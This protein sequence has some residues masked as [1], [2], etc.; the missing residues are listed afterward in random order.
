M[1]T[2]QTS[3][4]ADTVLDTLSAYWTLH[5]AMSRDAWGERWQVQS[6]EPEPAK[7]EMVLVLMTGKQAGLEFLIKIEPR[8]AGG[9]RVSV[10]YGGLALSVR[11]T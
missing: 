2:Y 5:R 3:L 8:P 9:T 6:G 1:K 4:L 11:L 7:A 10:G